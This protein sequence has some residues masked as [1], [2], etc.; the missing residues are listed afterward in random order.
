MH[1]SYSLRP[2]L[3]GTHVLQDPTLTINLINKTLITYHKN[4]TI[5][6]I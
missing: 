6:F 5:E 1:R 2:Y 3:G 4:Y